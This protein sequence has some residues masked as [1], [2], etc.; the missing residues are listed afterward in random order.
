MLPIIKTELFKMLTVEVTLTLKKPISFCMMLHTH[1]YKIFFFVD[2]Q[3]SVPPRHP[4]RW[5]RLLVLYHLD[6]LYPTNIN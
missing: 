6:V 4:I 5:N 2:S 3:V 1:V